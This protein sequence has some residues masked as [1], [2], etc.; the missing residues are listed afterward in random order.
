MRK[1]GFT[2]MEMILS[3]A[4]ISLIG[5][6]LMQAFYNG[7]RVWSRVSQVDGSVD[8]TI[9]LEKI[10]KDARTAIAFKGISFKGSSHRVQIPTI[11]WTQADAASQRRNEGRIDQIGAVQYS[12]DAAE[13]AIV[14]RQANYSQALKEQWSEGV[15]VLKGIKDVQWRYYAAT[16]KG[17]DMRTQWDEG[18]P[19]ALFIEIH[20]EDKGGERIVRRIM[21]IYVGGF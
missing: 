12:Y 7:T 15:V 1:P 18:V 21:P 11:I 10:E 6:A 20:F 2:L 3:T 9:F 5:V 8:T 13:N 14:R 16:D 19:A 4:M 17:F